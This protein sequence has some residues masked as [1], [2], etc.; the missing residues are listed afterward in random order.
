M[1]LRA[2]MTSG[3]ILIIEGNSPATR[4]TYSAIAAVLMLTVPPSPSN[5]RYF[6][7]FL[8]GMADSKKMSPRQIKA[9]PTPPTTIRL[10]II[11]EANSDQLS[12][13]RAH[14][15]SAPPETT[16][17]SSKMKPVILWI[18]FIIMIALRLYPA[19][20]MCKTRPSRA[21]R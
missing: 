11:T 12:P 1:L 9:T 14:T 17:T 18:I 20:L 21:R 19:A 10:P 3:F 4:A 13:D 8:L 16:T 7:C 2:G 6:C 5:E 15:T